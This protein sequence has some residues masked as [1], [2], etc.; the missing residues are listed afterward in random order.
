M[1]AATVAS[2]NQT[3]APASAVAVFPPARVP[4]S[5]PTATDYQYATE[6]D[7]YDASGREVNTASYV[8]GA[9]AV[10][11]TQY[12]TYGNVTTA[13]TADDRATALNSANP[14]GTAY[15]LSTVNVYGCDNF[16]AMDPSCSS[17]DQQYQV[18]TDTYGPAHD[19]S[20]GGTTKQVRTHTAYGYDNG[21]PNGDTSIDG[22]PY[23]LTT[24]QTVSASTGSGVPGT[25]TA[26]ARTTSYTYANSSTSIGWTTGAPLTTVTDPGGLNTTQTSVYNTSSTLYNGANLQTGSY[27]P[28]NTSGGGAGDTE[29]YYY[30]ADTSSPVSACQSKPEWAN[31]ICQTKPAAQPG[32]SGLPSLPV[33]T[34]LYGDYLNVATKTEAY[35]TTGTRTT[36]VSYDA[37]ERPATQAIAVTGTGMGTAVPKTQTVYSAAAGLPTDS[38]TLN[39]SGS[40]TA[41]ISSTYDD[42]GQALSYT[43]AAGNPTTYGYDING[44]PTSR[45]DGKGTETVTYDK[46]FGS[47]TTISDSQAGTFSA[48][49][50]PD[51]N[52]LTEQYPGTVKGTYT[53]DATGTPVSVSY[54][55]AAWTAP[56]TDTVVPDAAGNWASQ[57]VTDTGTTAPLVSTQVY[58]YDSAGRITGTQDAENG[59]C[60]TRAYAYDADSNRTRLTSYAPSSDGSCQNSTA[61]STATTSY[62]SADRDTNAGYAY[63]TQGDI[64]TTPSADAGGSGNLTAAYNANDMLASHAQGSKAI[65]WTLD[66]TLGRYGTSTQGG[67][68]YTSHYGD[69]GNSPAWTAGSDGSWTRNVTDFT[70]S[71]AAEVT[72]SGVTL[73]LTGLHGDVLATAT[74]SPTAN[75]PSSTY[76]YT[77][78]GTP[79]TGNPGTYGW[80]GADQI[81]GNALGGQLLMGARAYNTNS[82]RFSQAD[83]IPAAPRTLMTTCSRTRLPNSTSTE[84]GRG[85]TVSRYPGRRAPGIAITTSARQRPIESRLTSK[86]AWDGSPFAGL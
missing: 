17:S 23:M 10:T 40:V 42:F 75:G 20:T 71:L 61:S 8:N 63:N 68:T 49:Y 64:T 51:G 29:T 22:T 81:S 46:S 59:P 82:G 41:D 35:G 54:N 52:L 84:R 2:W 1:D 37:G 28:S 77:E 78:F 13:L 45:N 18:L 56:L 66:P 32:T 44:R 55:G 74:T 83:P 48:T 25:S 31:L 11:T 30:T 85:F 70:G 14:A 79:E 39:S 65:T 16:G 60:T 53:Y 57:S 80:L 5:P 26:D 86:E 73:E 4:S 12:D 3:D 76:A 33:T 38:Q 62:D 6:I 15:T 9:W 27:M 34:Y 36:T 7:Y 50:N 19:A 43:D 47:P 21:A 72:A 69:D 58:S 67:V 24:S